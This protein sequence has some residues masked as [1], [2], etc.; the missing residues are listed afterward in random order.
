MAGITLAQAEAKL[1]LYMDLDDKLGLNSETTIDGT[2]VKR[3]DVQAQIEYWNKWVI[4]LS[5][6]GGIPV[7]E[8]IPR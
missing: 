5:R 4:R 8:V 6:F 7:R 3:R 2:T 1:A